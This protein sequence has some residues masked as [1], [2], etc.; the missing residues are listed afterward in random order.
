MHVLLEAVD[1]SGKYTNGRRGRRRQGQAIVRVVPVV[2]DFDGSVEQGGTRVV[3][4]SEREEDVLS[5]PSEILI[6]RVSCLVCCV[7][8]LLVA[9]TSSTLAS[10]RGDF[11]GDGCQDLAIGVPLDDRG[12]QADAGQVGVFY[13]EGLEFCTGGLTMSG[14]RVLE[15]EAGF[16]RTRFGTS[17]ASGDFNGDGS[18]DIA[19][20]MLFGDERGAVWVAYGI[21]GGSF[22][23]GE[24][25]SVGDDG[26]RLGAAL[27][28][29]DF[30]GDGIHDLAAGAPRGGPARGGYVLLVR[31]GP[32]GIDESRAGL[33]LYQ[34]GP[35]GDGLAGVSERGDR[36]GAALAAGRTGG[37]S[38]AD[39]LVIGVPGEDVRGEEDAGAVNIDPGRIITQDTK[40]IRG[41]AEADDAFGFALTTGDF[42][43]FG[44]EDVAIGVPGEDLGRFG[45]AHGAVNVVY[46]TARDLTAANDD[47][48]TQDRRGIRD[49]AESGDGFGRSLVGQDFNIGPSSLAIGVPFEDVRGRSNAG[50]VHAIYGGPS[51]LTATDQL[52]TQATGKVPGTPETGDRFGSALAAAGWGLGI[53][54]PGEDLGSIARAGS[55]AVV[56]R[57]SS[58]L[59]PGRAE[60]FTQADLDGENPTDG[61]AFGASAASRAQ[62]GVYIPPGARL[63][64]R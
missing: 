6:G 25:V 1:R 56:Y 36:F 30:T 15:P 28:A 46:T 31:G 35:G 60:G 47:L 2:T 48:I 39:R 44:E 51:G 9:S 19:I 42:D 54:V 50:A 59:D 52:F 26:D 20:G 17:I 11:D 55:F 7:A 8:G 24:Y 13:H 16:G 57:G 53:G 41:A 32:G 10:D 63:T 34:G 27:T 62:S 58:L 12:S 21:G 61:D 33:G 4:A 43:D 49:T 23:N 37:A 40:G 5:A 14:N 38:S 18:A 64:G 3:R 45:N 29:G 22:I